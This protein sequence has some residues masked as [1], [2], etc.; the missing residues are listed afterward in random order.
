MLAHAAVRIAR[1][2]LDPVVLEPFCGVAPLAASVAAA[3]PGAELHV[4]DVDPVALTWA[5]QN[6]PVD[7]GV[8]E[9]AGLAE[10]PA[11]LRGRVSLVASVPPYVP[12]GERR[13]VPREA[14][15][16]EPPGALFAGSDGLDHVR[17]LVTDLV[18]W[19]RPDGRALIELN[20][21]Q[22]DAA[23]EHGRACGWRVSRRTGSDGQTA[24]LCLASGG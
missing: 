11:D 1:A 15:E 9:G 4:S 3:V 21:A 18:G 6:L 13:F 10:L 17:A 19:L 23:A 14:L 2:Q 20:R 7:A 12:D 5:R 16:H 22:W 8:H 24:L